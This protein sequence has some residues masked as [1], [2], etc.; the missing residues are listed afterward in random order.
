MKE[1]EV[2]IQNDSS[3]SSDNSYQCVF[4]ACRKL[5]YTF[6]SPLREGT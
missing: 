3:L 4:C 2:K 5:Y 6:P 1:L